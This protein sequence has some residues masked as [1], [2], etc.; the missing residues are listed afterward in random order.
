MELHAIGDAHRLNRLASNGHGWEEAL[1]HPENAFFD[2]NG[3][4]QGLGDCGQ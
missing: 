1:F 3:A 2:Y 4:C